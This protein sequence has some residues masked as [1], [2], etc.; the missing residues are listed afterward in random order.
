[1]YVQPRSKLSAS[2]VQT[3]AITMEES[4]K[5]TVIGAA[6]VG[7]IIGVYFG[8]ELSNGIVCAA[9]L[10]YGATLG[11]RFGDFAKSSGNTA[12]KVYSKTLELNEQYDVLP[13][14]KTAADVVSTAAGNLNEN[15]GITKKVDAQL[16][17]SPALDKA[18]ANFDNFK[19]TVTSKVDDLKTKASN[20]ED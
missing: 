7:G 13:K 17:I 9:I 3:A 11:N 8:H 20:T 4:S 5:A 12:A 6:A 19:S 14:V 15:Y 10:A 18:V 16:K 1:M 2:R